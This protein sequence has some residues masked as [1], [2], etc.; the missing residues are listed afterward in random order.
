MI[1]NNVLH[2]REDTMH[3]RSVGAIVSTAGRLTP[4]ELRDIC[5]LTGRK[6]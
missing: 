3:V 1:W 5:A 4:T 2:E 6:A